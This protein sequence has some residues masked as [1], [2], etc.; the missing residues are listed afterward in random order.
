[1]DGM[2]RELGGPICSPSPPLDFPMNE[3]TSNF[4]FEE[5]LINQQNNM[6][7]NT[8]DSI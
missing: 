6:L 5:D 7:S 2:V 1:M 8:G 3:S 4:N